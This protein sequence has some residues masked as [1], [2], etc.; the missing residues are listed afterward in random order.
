MTVLISGGVKN[1]KTY[2]A[3][4]L[5]KALSGKGP[6]YYIATMAPVDR[7]DDERIARHIAEREGWGFETIECPTDIMSCVYRGRPQGVFLLDSTTALLANEM[8]SKDGSVDHRAAERVAEEIRAFAS[9]V[10]GL[11]VVSDSIYSDAQTYSELTQEYR[12]GLAYIDRA[13]AKSFD[14]VYEACCGELFCHKG[15]LWEDYG[16]EPLVSFENKG[17]GGKV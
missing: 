12:I 3:Q 5:A 13:L 8:F 16:K 14:N 6:L 1:G 2:H 17:Q 7:E 4:R 9:C 11:V 10:E 15:S